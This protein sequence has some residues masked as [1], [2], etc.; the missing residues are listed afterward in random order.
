[1]FGMLFLILNY[2]YFHNSEWLWVE[3]NDGAKTALGLQN[4][5][6]GVQLQP[7]KNT[8]RRRALSKEF[9]LRASRVTGGPHLHI[10]LPGIGGRCALKFKEF[11]L[12]LQ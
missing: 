5:T 6:L 3:E 11:I 8:K 1:M 12:S 10:L 7:Q 4:L 9:R 2:I